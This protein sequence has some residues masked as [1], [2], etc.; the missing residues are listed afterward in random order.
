VTIRLLD[1]PLHE[2][3]PH[4][5]AEID[6]VAKAMGVSPKTIKAKTASLHE[7]NP[8]LGH[9]GCRLGVTYPEIYRMQV[10]AIVEAAV[11]VK[12]ANKINVHPEIMIR[13]SGT[14]KNSTCCAKRL[15]RSSPKCWAGKRPSSTS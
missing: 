10:R 9:R 1:P 12:T 14:S 15:K 5:P 4:T 13:W 2:F 3:L 8:M 11:Q 6:E 7:F